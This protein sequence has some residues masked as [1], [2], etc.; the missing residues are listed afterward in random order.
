M[1]RQHFYVFVPVQHAAYIMLEL[2]Y[3]VKHAVLPG[4]QLQIG[5][6]D[7]VD[8]H[9]RSV[10][11]LYVRRINIVKV[12]EVQVERLVFIVAPVVDVKAQKLRYVARLTRS[13][14][15]NVFSLDTLCDFF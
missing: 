2:D 13:V 10:F 12:V 3:D 4:L 6:L 1:V 15:R 7:R 9:F 8:F 5:G 11:K 14:R